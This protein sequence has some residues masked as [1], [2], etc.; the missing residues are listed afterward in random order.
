M[1]SLGL[2]LPLPPVS[3]SRKVETNIYIR[4][5]RFERGEIRQLRV[6]HPPEFTRSSSPRPFS[7]L[8]T[9]LRH[10]IDPYGCCAQLVDFRI[11]ST[12][13][14][15]HSF[16]APSPT[17]LLRPSLCHDLYI[18]TASLDSYTIHRVLHL[19]SIHHPLPRSRHK[20]ILYFCVPRISMSL[21]T[22]TRKQRFSRRCNR[23]KQSNPA[24]EKVL[25]FCS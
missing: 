25:L 19:S 18:I 4:A 7:S 20:R 14:M 16:T 24:V 21:R 3:L 22:P 12:P 11:I 1:R 9:T 13:P 6:H 23:Y 5:T 2:S 15:D 17:R 10:R 8:P